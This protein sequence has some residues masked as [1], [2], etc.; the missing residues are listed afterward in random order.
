M[1]YFID[2]PTNLIFQNYCYRCNIAKMGIRLILHV[3]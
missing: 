1:Y 3:Q 2:I